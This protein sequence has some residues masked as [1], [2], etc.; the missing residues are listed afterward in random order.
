MIDYSDLKPHIII[1]MKKFL[2]ESE[3]GNIDF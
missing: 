1:Q 3:L 2:Y